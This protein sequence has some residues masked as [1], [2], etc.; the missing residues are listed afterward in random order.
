M[1]AEVLGDS[2]YPLGFGPELG[3]VQFHLPHHGRLL[4]AFLFELFQEGWVGRQPNRWAGCERRLGHS[5]SGDVCLAQGSGVRVS[6]LFINPL[7]RSRYA[8]GYWPL[9]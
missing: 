2:F 7:S 5:D 3:R 4:F 1:E 8:L 6:G 9:R